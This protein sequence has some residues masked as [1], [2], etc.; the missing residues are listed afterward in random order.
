MLLIPQTTSAHHQ[1]TASG[2]L[3]MCQI[4][5]ALSGGTI[6][7]TQQISIIAAVIHDKVASV[8]YF[9]RLDPGSLFGALLILI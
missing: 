5:I 4:F 3:I 6:I 8:K 7:L 1:A 9:A 2:T